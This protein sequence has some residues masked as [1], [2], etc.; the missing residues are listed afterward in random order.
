VLFVLMG[1]FDVG[2]LRKRLVASAAPQIHSLA[3]LPLRNLS[4]DPNQEYFSDGLTDELITDLAQIRSIKVISHTST[5]Q[6]KDAKKPL[7]EIAAELN[8]DGI[9]E[10]T[11]QRS[12]DRVRIT[13]QLIYA[14]SDKHVWA[15]AYERDVSDLFAL[16]GEVTAEIS[17]QVQARLEPQGRAALPRPINPKALDSY[18]E[19][20]YHLSRYGEG[21]GEEELKKAAAYFQQAID[22]DPNFAPAYNGLSSAHGQLIRA[23]REDVAIQRKAAEKA[24]ELDP[25]YADAH[26]T[27]GFLK[28]QP[29]LDWRGAEEQLRQAIALSPNNAGA[30]DILGLLL[31]TTG[32]AQEGLREG[33]IAQQLDPNNDHLSL[34]LFHAR[35][36]DASIK[37]ALWMLRKD[38]NNGMSHCLLFSVYFKKESYREAVDELSQCYSLYGYTKVASHLRQAFAVSGY[39][40][41]MREFAKDLERLQA[42]NE[43]Y[44]PGNLVYAY[45]ILGDKDRAF[46]WLEQAYAHREMVSID[47][48]IFFLRS[49]P[50]Y[51]PLRSDPR[52]EDLLRRIGLPP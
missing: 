20:S 34:I 3:V 12:G 30:H 9:I 29:D 52:Y 19:G 6:Y 22:A 39:R 21:S 26:V 37:M 46:Y 49:E 4:S 51:D 25:N 5:M 23:S 24:V 13:A 42:T 10:G 36:Y 14:P 45:T 41:A 27:L 35:D 43:V 18:L 44:L 28:W 11:V 33:Q 2:G 7:P 31:V 32:R 50:M 1:V 15:H 17:R 16:E 48:G 38:P 40:G 8:V 47:A